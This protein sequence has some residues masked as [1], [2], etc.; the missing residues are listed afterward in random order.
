M[1]VCGQKN[2]HSTSVASLTPKVTRGSLQKAVLIIINQDAV[3]DINTIIKTTSVCDGDARSVGGGRGWLAGDTDGLGG[4]GWRGRHATASSSQEQTM[5]GT[6]VR[7]HCTQ[8]LTE[9]GDGYQ[10]SLDWGLFRIT[11]NN[12]CVDVWQINHLGNR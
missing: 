1:F 12:Q 9:R 10:C 6:G 2:T 11:V 7:L 8:G 3:A 4:D 5:S